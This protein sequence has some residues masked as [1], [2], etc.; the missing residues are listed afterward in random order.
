VVKKMLKKKRG[1][2]EKGG[3]SWS[4]DE[5]LEKRQ[6]K[7]GRLRSTWAV[8]ISRS[9]K[10]NGEGTSVSP[11]RER[12]RK[13]GRG[14]KS[15]KSLLGKNPPGKVGSCKRKTSREK[16]G[17]LSRRLE[18]TRRGWDLGEKREDQLQVL[19]D[20]AGVGNGRKTE[21]RA[22]KATRGYKRRL[23]GVQLADARIETE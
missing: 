22:I 1:N 19:L 20:G 2:K 11:L 3:T 5:H 10:L 13:K 16:E 15:K 14:V 7:R 8:I 12:G 6:W 4:K 18:E 21:G 17:P 23:S 9:S